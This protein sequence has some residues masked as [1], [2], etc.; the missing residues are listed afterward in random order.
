MKQ[1]ILFSLLVCLITLQ[2]EGY[3]SHNYRTRTPLTKIGRSSIWATQTTIDLHD[4]A[5]SKIRS[6]HEL[7][8]FIH[9]LCQHL[10]VT[11]YDDATLLYHY[12]GPGYTSGYTATQQANGHT[13]IAIRVNEATNNVHIDIFSCTPYDPYDVA[14]Q[15]RTF[16][17]AYNMD[18][19]VNY[20]K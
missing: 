18:F 2:A 9:Q 4:C 10:G 6:E 1:S 15:A 13:D 16:F 3:R 8:R 17:Y 12:S 5:H 14:Q 20:R 7:K 11:Q 19:K